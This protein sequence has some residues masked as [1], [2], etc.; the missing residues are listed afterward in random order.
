MGVQMVDSDCTARNFSLG[1]SVNSNDGWT[2]LIFL[3]IVHD[4]RKAQTCIE[5][6]ALVDLVQRSSRYSASDLMFEKYQR[7][8]L[9]FSFRTV[10]S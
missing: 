6:E 7:C 4:I 5:I 1:Q 9:W 3:E 2:N 8:Y 10:S